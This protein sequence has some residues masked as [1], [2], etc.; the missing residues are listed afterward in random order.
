ME[1]ILLILVV[2]IISAFCFVIGARVGQ[3]V[4]RGETIETP[5]RNPIK[6]VTEA[7]DTFE[8]RKIQERDRI[9]ADNI[10]NY[11]GTATGQQDVP[12]I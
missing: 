3:K 8:Q 10:D 2:G 9:I 11:D 7:V 12:K 4:V 6:V 1:T 5:L